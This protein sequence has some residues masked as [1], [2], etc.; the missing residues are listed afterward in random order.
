MHR[1]RFFVLALISF[2]TT[3]ICAFLTPGKFLH[4]IL[5]VT[6]CT[7]F[8]LNSTL[9]AANLVRSDDQVV[10][11]EP[12]SAV[13]QG[14]VNNPHPTQ[15]QLNKPNVNQPFQLQ[16]STNKSE[17]LKVFQNI[18]PELTPVVQIPILLPTYIPDLD[19]SYPVHAIIETKT[20]LQYRILLAFSEDCTG[21][22][23]CR[24]GMISGESINP[25]TQSVQGESVSLNNG[26][27][28]YFVDA[29]CGANCTDSILTWDK[30]GYRYT[31]AVKAANLETLVKMADS[32]TY[33]SGNEKSVL[34]LYKKKMSRVHSSD[35]PVPIS[36]GSIKE[37]IK[38]ITIDKKVKTFVNSCLEKLISETPSSM[39]KYAKNSIPLILEEAKKAGV[40]D[41]KQLAYI[42]ATAQHESHLGQWMQEFASGKQYEGRKDLGNTESGDGMRFKGRGFVQVT[43]RKNYQDWSNRLEIDLIKNPEKAADPKIAADIL[44]RGMRDGTFTGKKLSDYFNDS[45]RD[46]RNARRIVNG[47]DKAKLIEEYAEKYLKVLEDTQSGCNP[48]EEKSKEGEQKKGTSY[49]DPHMIT[50]DR[51]KY[52]FQTVGEFTLVKSTDENFEVQVRQG[53]IS[54][55]V[56]INTAVAMKI[57]NSRITLYA[58]NLPDSDTNTPLRIDGKPTKLENETLEL[59]GGGLI[60]GNSSNYLIT[61]PTGEQVGVRIG[62]ERMDIT[63]YISAQSGQYIGLLGNA[64]GDPTDDLQTRAGKVI[65]TKENSTYGQLSEALSNVLPVPAPLTQAE[66]IFFD[67]VYKEF[68]DSWRITQAESLFDYPPGKDTGT[69]TNRSFPNSYLSLNSLLPPQIRQAEE[70]CRE[71]GVESELLDGCIFDVANTGDASFA[72]S[73]ANALTD[74]IKDRVEQE[75]RDRIPLPGGINIPGL[76]F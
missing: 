10:A 42:L 11:A 34:N 76:P 46:F 62:K 66:K 52:S 63:P 16:S 29:T 7:V 4:R 47:L 54:N 35:T 5:S 57:G 60:Q 31:V 33:F 58:K 44:V 49:G 73:A 12:P 17:S 13:V 41:P 18:L 53:A 50:F 45:T 15:S 9:C 72:E 2:V 70:I 61:A 20:A 38:G 1:I 36:V 8:S 39:R 68:G 55:S 65:P 32:M 30:N 40:N 67:I 27:T 56:S 69:Y 22:N 23:A 26:I 71:A 74:I 64:N 51:F 24:L 21:G 75:I 3:L 37:G 48:Q 28:G 59:P 19:D 25:Q 43:G 14:I 6:A